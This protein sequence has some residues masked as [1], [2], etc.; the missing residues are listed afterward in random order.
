MECLQ[1]MAL[2]MP[3]VRCVWSWRQWRDG[4]LSMTD[5]PS[6]WSPLLTGLSQTWLLLLPMDCLV[7]T[8]PISME[9]PRWPRCFRWCGMGLWSG[10]PF[11]LKN[12]GGDRFKDR[13]DEWPF[14]TGRSFTWNSGTGCLLHAH[15]VSCIS[16]S[17]IKLWSHCCHGYRAVT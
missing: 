4:K 1:T 6:P 7:E 16:S 14:V 17:L 13:H 5:A 10:V 9:R 3:N 2:S 8:G 15:Y 12:N 11:R